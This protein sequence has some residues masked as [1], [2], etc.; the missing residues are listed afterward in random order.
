[1]Q[2]DL[3]VEHYSSGSDGDNMSETSLTVEDGTKDLMKNKGNFTIA[4]VL[5]LKNELSY[6]K[7]V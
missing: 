3:N 2:E 1:M 5:S 7:Y 6:V 4:F